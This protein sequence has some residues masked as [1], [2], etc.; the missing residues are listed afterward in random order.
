MDDLERLHRRAR[1]RRAN[2]IIYG[3]VRVLFQ[4]FFLTYFRMRRIGRE[5]IPRRGPVI[6]ASNHRSF[7]DP[8]VIAC[9]ARRPM[10]YVAKQEIFAYSRALSWLLAA[11]GAFPVRRDAGDAEFITTAT[12]IL[13]RGD[14]VLIFPEGT[15]TRPGPLGRPRRGFARLALETGAPIVPVAV[16]GTEAVRRGWR[17][18][19]HRVAIRAGRALAFPRVA[20]P[21][22]R[23]AA[24]VADRV[25]P[26]VMLQWE[27]LGGAPPP[28]RAAIL[29]AGTAG[30]ALAV[31]L[32][33]AGLEVQLAVPDEARAAAIAMER[34]NAD[35]LPGVAIPHGVDVLAGAGFSPAGMDLLI[36]DGSDDQ[37]ADMLEARL[38]ATEP[39]PGCGLAIL[40]CGAPAPDGLRAAAVERA[41]GRALATIGVQAEPAA[42]AHPG[43][44]VSVAC[45]DRVLARALEV[46]LARA[47]LEVRVARDG[48]RRERAAERRPVGAAAARIG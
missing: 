25:W 4:A 43:A 7:L 26:C 24:A 6:I 1:E 15:R 9:M 16:I 34:E 14:I 42:L 11:V 19:P 36:V 48:V 27:A 22:P 31:S 40:Y 37:A 8:F 21:S 3:V 47:G 18:R 28:R 10:Y 46:V 23:L 13:R 32:A 29:G 39:G 38:A 41:P 5:H 44:R 12:A 35:A 17:I 2:P 45:P 33:R 30:T 20:H